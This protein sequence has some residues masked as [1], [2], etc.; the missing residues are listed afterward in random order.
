LKHAGREYLQLTSFALIP[1]WISGPGREE[2]MKR[3]FG[4][5][6]RS[7]GKGTFLGPGTELVID[8]EE[9]EKVAGLGLVS[10]GHTSNSLSQ[11]SPLGEIVVNSNDSG[12]LILPITIGVHT[13][14]VWWEYSPLWRVKHRQAPIYR[15]W[16]VSCRGKEFRAHEYYTLYSFPHPQAIKKIQFRNV[17]Q[18]SGLSIIDLILI[19]SPAQGT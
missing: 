5:G 13:A 19:P 14:E 4:D 9:K 2:L 17:S 10:Y 16:P 18:K 15:S 1:A 7:L 12:E 8:F 11:G 3:H 6:A